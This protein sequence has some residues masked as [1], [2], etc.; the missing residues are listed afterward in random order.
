MRRGREQSELIKILAAKASVT[1]RAVR[2]WRDQNDSRWIKFLAERAAAGSL[3]ADQVP[4]TFT[5]I[6]T[7]SDEE[8]SHEGQIRRMREKIADLS[9]RADLA[10]RAG[11]I[12]SETLLR[13]MHLAHMEGARR[14]EKDAPG[15]ARDSGDVIPKR[16]AQQAIIQYSAHVAAAISNLPDR[17]LSLLPSLESSLCEK[18]RDEIR[19]VMQSARE[20]QLNAPGI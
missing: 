16:V 17:I 2:K 18:I 20:I 15:I 11:D 8:L 14:L 1:P 3:R 19:D 9:R 10:Q 4:E 12:D 5:E 7:Y 6:P 13:K